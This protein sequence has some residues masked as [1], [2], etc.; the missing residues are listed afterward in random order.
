LAKVKG[1]I[2]LPVGHDGR[3]RADLFPFGTKTTRNKPNGKEFLFSLPKWMWSLA[4]PGPGNGL[5]Y[6]DWK[7]QEWGIAA[8]LSGDLAMQD[9]YRSEDPYLA[10]ANQAGAAPSGATKESHGAVRD[11]F[12]ALALAANYGMGTDSLAQKING[13]KIEALA[14]RERWGRA[15]PK[16]ESWVE[17]YKEGAMLHAETTTLLGWRRRLVGE[18][19]PRSVGNFP[20]Q[21]CAAEMLRVASILMMHAGIRIC[22]PHHDAFLIEAPIQDLGAAIETTQHCMRDASWALLNGFE[23][24]TDVEVVAK[25]PDRYV[26]AKGADLWNT[27]L[28]LLAEVRPSGWPEGPSGGP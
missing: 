12:K 10:L 11:Q 6:I 27:I 8:A 2:A 22:I 15:F 17:S 16:Y 4:R 19:N 9:M 3:A 1:E 5:A 25:Y 20:V 18:V 13:T 24:G 7:Q 23:L 28:E 14:L 21:S 26:D